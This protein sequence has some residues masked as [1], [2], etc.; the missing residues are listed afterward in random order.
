MNA[1][2]LFDHLD[3][4]TMERG[5]TTSVQLLVTQIV[6]DPSNE[7]CIVTSNFVDT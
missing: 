3:Y 4:G 7:P 5:S 6:V 1:V 2:F